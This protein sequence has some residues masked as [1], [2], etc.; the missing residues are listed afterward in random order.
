MFSSLHR[1]KSALLAFCSAALLLSSCGRSAG[2]FVDRGNQLFAD[3][4]YEEAEL[5]YR[6]AIQKD[7]KS[8][9]AYYRLALAELRLG[10]VPNAYQA[11]NTAVALSPANMDAKAQLADVCM[12]GYLLVPNRPVVLYNRA[13]SLSDELLA[14]NP[15]SA[16]G[17]RVKGGLAL[18]DNHPAEALDFY[19]RALAIT[20]NA[21]RVEIGVAE[22]LVKNGQLAEAEQQTR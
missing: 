9:E 18:I 16:D 12:A 21:E 10:H 11:L 6:N 7:G 15:K 19:R 4:K 22:A 1:K 3:G 14:A 20:P 8:G 13:R 17:L 2:Q 5:N